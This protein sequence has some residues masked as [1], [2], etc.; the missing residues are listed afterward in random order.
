MQLVSGSHISAHCPGGQLHGSLC[1]SIWSTQG[2][3]LLVFIANN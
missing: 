2:S 1:I 3:S